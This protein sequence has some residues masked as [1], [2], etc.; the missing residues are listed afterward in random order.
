MTRL[1]DA[2]DLELYAINTGEFYSLHK[3]LVGKPIYDWFRHLNDIVIPH[4]SRKIEPVHV[5]VAT[6]AAVT[7]RLRDYYAR[8][9]SE[10]AALKK[11]SDPAKSA[12][13]ILDK[14]A[15]QHASQHG[16]NVIPATAKTLRDALHLMQSAADPQWIVLIGSIPDGM[17]AVGTFPD[18]SA[19][20][21]FLDAAAV[22]GWPM[23]LHVPADNVQDA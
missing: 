16:P 15:S 2:R 23:V 17:F 13:A 5:N 14:R 7:D 22:E 19:A 4:Y 3:G 6:L 12:S 18:Q 10:S 9:V 20:V 8:H 1:V 11:Q 21:S